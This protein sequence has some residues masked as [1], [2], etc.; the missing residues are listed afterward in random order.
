MTAKTAL[1]REISEILDGRTFF[2]KCEI[3]EKG[4]APGV[5]WIGSNGVTSSVG[6]WMRVM[7]RELTTPGAA[8]KGLYR[9]FAATNPDG[10]HKMWYFGAQIGDTV[11]CCGGATDL[12]G[13]GDH[14]KELGDRFLEQ[15]GFPVTTS[16]ASH[17]VGMLIDACTAAG[18]FGAL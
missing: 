12:S 17:L 4:V 15:L 2:G 14:G 10:S 11:Y 6:Q 18:H 13:E 16:P 7:M 1:D 9:W 3:K 8:L 5:V